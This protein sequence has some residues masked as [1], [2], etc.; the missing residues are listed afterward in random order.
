MRVLVQSVALLMNDTL[1]NDRGR[2]DS[3]TTRSLIVASSFDTAITD[4]EHAEAAQRIPLVD[5][6]IANA[7]ILRN[8]H[9]DL[10][11][12]YYYFRNSMLRGFVSKVRKDEFGEKPICA[13]C[14]RS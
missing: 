9:G 12:E 8:E 6:T 5:K 10:A 4:N 13:D 7:S 14:A 3:A 2:N 11:I 1:F